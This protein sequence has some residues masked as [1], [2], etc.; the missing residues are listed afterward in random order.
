MSTT[1]EDDGQRLVQFMRG[2]VEKL[3]TIEAALRRVT[4][5]APDNVVPL[6]LGR[7]PAANA[8]APAP[9]ANAGHSDT[10]DK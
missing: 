8:D 6:A 1:P 7:K 10:T 3:E 9:Q 2:M 5:T 4:A